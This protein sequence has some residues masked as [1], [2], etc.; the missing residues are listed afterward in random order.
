EEASYIASLTG[1]S[2]SVLHVIHGGVGETARA[3]PGPLREAEESAALGHIE[4]AYPLGEANKTQIAV[5]RGNVT[6]EI[7]EHAAETDADLIV[8]GARG[9][10]RLDGFLGGG[11]IAEKVARNSKVPVVIVYARA[12]D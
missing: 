7:L 8:I 6:A 11:S 4:R 10:G 1:A 12:H 9:I 3:V 5:R 2:L